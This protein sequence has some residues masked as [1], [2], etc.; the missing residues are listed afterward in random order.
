MRPSVAADGSPRLRA[1][2][3]AVRDGRTSRPVSSSAGTTG[4]SRHAGSG[5][6]SAT[7]S[8]RAGRMDSGHCPALSRPREL[9]E[10]LERYLSNRRGRRPDQAA[11]LR[12]F[13]MRFVNPVT[14]R[15]A[16]TFRAS[17]RLPRRPTTGPRLRD[18]DERVPRWLRLVM[19]LTY[20]SQSPWV[21]NSSHWRLRAR[22]PRPT[23]PPHRPELIHDPSRRLMPIRSMVPWLLGATDFLAGSGRVPAPLV[24]GRRSVMRRDPPLP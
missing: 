14:E 21:R 23:R 19:A 8:D 10:L 5:P 18:P 16:G 3:L 2:N 13:T 12:P 1:G 20:G 11:F 9:A 22:V 17:H 4:S 15:F 24:G 7:G 6:S